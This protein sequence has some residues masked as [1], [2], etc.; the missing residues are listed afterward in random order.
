MRRGPAV[1][2]DQRMDER[3]LPPRRM[4]HARRLGNGNV[5]VTTRDEA[6]R[7]THAVLYDQAVVRVL[8]ELSGEEAE[9]AYGA[10]SR[11]DDASFDA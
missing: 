9:A 4:R 10:S 5:V 3:Y 8:E 11:V 6:G 7:V 1:G 2:D